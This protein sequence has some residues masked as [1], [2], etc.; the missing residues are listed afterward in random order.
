MRPSQQHDP[1]S[2][3]QPV[4]EIMAS[5]QYL[6]DL[7][8]QTLWLDS[9]PRQHPQGRKTGPCDRHYPTTR[10]WSGRCRSW[11]YTGSDPRVIMRIRG[12][13]VGREV[14]CWSSCRKSLDVAKVHRR[15]LV[16]DALVESVFA[17]HRHRGQ[18]ESFTI[19][20]VACHAQWLWSR[21]PAVWS[22]MDSNK[23]GKQPLRTT[24]L[25]W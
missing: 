10:M 25:T 17:G 18:E 14:S 2:T 11:R 5:T 15:R 20:A 19:A 4:H 8:M 3:A 23:Q 22:G 13:K 9:A 1:T 6:H 7:L 16:Y 24:H 12:R 21:R